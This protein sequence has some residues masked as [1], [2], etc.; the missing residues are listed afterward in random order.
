MNYITDLSH[1]PYDELKLLEDH[2]LHNRV[3]DIIPSLSSFICIGDRSGGLYQVQVSVH[4]ITTT[5][6]SSL[7]R[8]TSKRSQHPEP[9]RTFIYVDIPRSILLC[10]LSGMVERYEDVHGVA[11]DSRTFVDL[12]LVQWIFVFLIAGL[13]IHLYRYSVFVLQTQKRAQPSQSIRAFV[14]GGIYIRGPF[15]RPCECSLNGFS[16][17]F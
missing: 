8:A 10:S 3:S 5:I 9:S 12:P 11:M 4:S 7:R 17:G 14:L 16:L 2:I 1:Q 6:T 13:I 15:W